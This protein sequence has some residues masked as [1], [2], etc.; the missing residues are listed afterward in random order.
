MNGG[1]MIEVEALFEAHLA[2]TDLDKAIAFYRDVIG[3]RLAH[4]SSA[5]RAAFF[6]I[7][8]AGGGILGLWTAGSAPQSG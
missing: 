4:V 6:W 5:R 7:G 1:R 3:L 8:S 2:V